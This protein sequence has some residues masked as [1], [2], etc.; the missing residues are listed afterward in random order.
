MVQLSAY[1]SFDAHAIR[2]LHLFAGKWSP[3]IQ[4]GA[5]CRERD[6][7]YVTRVATCRER[8]HRYVTRVATC[9]ERDH[10]YVTR[11]GVFQ[12]QLD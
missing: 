10:R 3:D 2:L 7:R 5:T 9:R 8:D 6:H 1:A 12:D 4:C 11:G